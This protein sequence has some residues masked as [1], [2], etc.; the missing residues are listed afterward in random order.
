[1]DSRLDTHRNRRRGVCTWGPA[2]GIRSVWASA[3]MLLACAAL[4]L[5]GCGNASR[6]ANASA[7]LPKIPHARALVWQ[8]AQTPVSL[9]LQTPWPFQPPTLAVAPSNGN[10]AYEC[11]A[12]ASATSQSG[13]VWVT[14]DR[15]AHWT[16][17]ADLP[18]GG[19]V[20]SCTI[21][22][23]DLTPT[24]A[25]AMTFR[26]ARDGCFACAHGTRSYFLTTDGGATWTPQSG[27]V[28]PIG[29]FA[30]ARGVTYAL[31]TPP[32]ADAQPWQ[33]TLLVSRD[34]MRT[35]SPIDQP[36]HA[37]SGHAVMR[38]WLSPATG[39][40]LAYASNSAAFEEQVWLSRDGGGQ[41]SQLQGAIGQEYIVRI[42]DAGQPWY[43]CGMRDGMDSTH[44]VGPNMLTCSYDS[45]KT[46][47]GAGGPGGGPYGVQNGVF[48][49][50]DD[51]SVLQTMPLSTTPT[52]GATTPSQVGRLIPRG[53]TW[54]PL[55]P[56]P[57][58][59]PILYASGVLWMT[60]QYAGGDP[61]GTISTASYT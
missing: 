57:T 42:P 5:A 32:L 31:N 53:T 15:A 51:G 38:F 29:Q 61:H 59:G 55:G 30:T 11:Y 28:F 47:H 16:R 8:D 3:S 48:A 4:L 49:F 10:V 18:T 36:I 27:S 46:W 12:P 50:A 43:I 13:Q 17:A 7:P 23:N 56:A 45:G 40:L 60:P 22:V 24:T 41:W 20:D 52:L 2:W 54:E 6:P 21:T 26:D 35:W 14:R 25:V 1:M 37:S 19:E 44:P 33:S 58:Y 34:G 39:E 9:V